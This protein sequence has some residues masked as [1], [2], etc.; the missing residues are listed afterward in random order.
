[1]S[2]LRLC[3]VVALALGVLF[4]GPVGLLA[5]EEHGGQEHAGTETAADDMA[6]VLGDVA[7]ALEAI[8]PDL[9]ASAKAWAEG[10]GTG[11]QT[12]A[13]ASIADA[14]E[15]TDPDLAGKVRGLVQ[16]E[17][18]GQEHGGEATTT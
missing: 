10:T 17:H 18:G 7:A 11:D 2:R 16:K 8:N 1:M 6:K 3:L 12:E 4:Y 9:A 15:A 5:Q 14:L 13:L